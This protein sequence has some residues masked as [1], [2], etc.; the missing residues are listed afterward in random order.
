MIVI[1][2]KYVKNIFHFVQMLIMLVSSLSLMFFYNI[3]LTLIAIALS[4]LPMLGAI[5]LGGKLAEKEKLVSETNEVYVSSLK[6]ILSGFPTIKTFQAE[7]DVHLQFDDINQMLE[8][9]KKRANQT[10]ELIVGIGGLTSIIAQIGVMLV[11]AYFVLNE[12]NHVT[13]GMVIAFTNLMNFVI[14]PLAA[15]PQ[16]IGE[17]KSAKELI[18]KL[19]E[20]LVNSC[21][22]SGNEVLEKKATPPFIQLNNVSYTHPDGNIGLSNISLN[23]KPGKIYGVVGSSGS[24]KST[25]LNLLMKSHQVY[26]GEILIDQIDLQQITTESLYQSFSLIQQEVFI[27]NTTIENNVTMFK[28]FSKDQIEKA[29]RISGL[30]TLIEAK[31]NDYKVGENGKY[32]SGG[33]RQRIAIAR[34]LIRANS[35]VLVDEVTSALDNL[36]AQQINQ[37]ILGLE[38]T[39]RVVVTHRLD[40]QTLSHFDEILVMK[41]GQVVEV[42]SFQTLMAQKGYFY[43]LFMVEN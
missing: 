12:A 40:E 28:Q 1:Q 7:K 39:T 11:G 17:R 13:I 6:D 41:K 8:R 15:I 18:H 31:G 19:S 30:S 43:S 10:E 20:N 29:L 33:E 22:D 9:N 5:L 38:N 2:D 14:Q 42:G 26:T 37:T 32:L 21:S 34:A 16:I 4:I 36:T 3:S 35:V 23:L 25:L 24:G 27:F